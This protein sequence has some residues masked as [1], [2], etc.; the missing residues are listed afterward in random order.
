M[1]VGL[2]TGPLVVGAMG[3]ARR[4]DYTAIGDPV[5]VASRLCAA[6]GDGILCGEATAGRVPTADLEPVAP[7]GLKGKARPVR[8]FK[9]L[10]APGAPP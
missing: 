2:D 3:C 8:A 1:G 9:V 5:N 7:L 4:L 6:A 10:G